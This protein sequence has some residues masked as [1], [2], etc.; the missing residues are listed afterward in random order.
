MPGAAPRRYAGNFYVAATTTVVEYYADQLEHYFMT[1]TP[2]EITRLDAR[3]DFKR[4]G[5]RFKAWARA[6]DAP[7]AASPVCRFYASGPNS[8]FYTADTGECES[9]KALEQKDKASLPK[10]EA[11]RAW[12]YEGIAFYALVPREGKSEPGT[13]P[14]YRFYNNRWAEGDSNHRFTVT[15]AMRL[16]MYMSW[17]D[18]GVAFCSPE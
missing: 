6:S 10:G 18:E 3:T 9:L 5:Q 13:T 16:A 15:S 4:T 14:V 7:A 1:A 17:R 2:D 11:Y 8:H 12:Q